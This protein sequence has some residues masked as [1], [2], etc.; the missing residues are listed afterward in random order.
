MEITAKEE[1]HILG[2]FQDFKKALSFQE[3]VY[4]NFAKNIFSIL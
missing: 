4:E 3:L 2:I 1:V